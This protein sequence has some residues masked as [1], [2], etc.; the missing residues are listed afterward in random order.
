MFEKFINNEICRKIL[1]WLMNHNTGDYEAAIIAFDCQ[2]YNIPLF[3]TYIYIFD[4]L[5]I[6]SIDESSETLRIIFN[7]D[8]LIVQS[9]KTL[10]DSF[11]SEA[12]RNSN[13][14]AAFVSIDSGTFDVPGSKLASYFEDLSEEEKKDFYTLI[15]NYKDFEISDDP[16][17]SVVQKSLIS[18]L[19][20]LDEN[21]L[22][23]TFIEYVKR[24][25][26]I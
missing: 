15:T 14:C 17:R 20:E 2:I 25:L 8:S 6:V 18:Q 10:R 19:E 11:D 4:E 9:F 5:G 3:T 13:V 16:E 7:E 24:N 1:F 26:Y 22:L 12:Y 23:D 21:G